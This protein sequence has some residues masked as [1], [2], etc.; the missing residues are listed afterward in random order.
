[1][2][3]TAFTCALLSAQQRSFGGLTGFLPPDLLETS[4]SFMSVAFFCLESITETVPLELSNLRVRQMAATIAGNHA[5]LAA[6]R[7]FKE[8]ATKTVTVVSFRPCV[9]RFRVCVFD[10]Q[11]LFAEQRGVLWL[12]CLVRVRCIDFQKVRCRFL[13]FLAR[14]RPKVLFEVEWVTS[15]DQW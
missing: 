7:K 13:L 3:C 9:G 4:G 6:E 5:R 2:P 10:G 8:M 14:Q 11:V 12:Y 1:M 15:I